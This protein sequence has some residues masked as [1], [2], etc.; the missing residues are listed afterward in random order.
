MPA[1]LARRYDRTNARRHTPHSTGDDQGN[2]Q[3]HDERTC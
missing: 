2:R 1:I 3:R